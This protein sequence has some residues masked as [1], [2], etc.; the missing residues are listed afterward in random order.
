MF[1]EI[2][3]GNVYE[4]FLEKKKIEYKLTQRNYDE[5]SKHETDKMKLI[6]IIRKPK[7]KLTEFPG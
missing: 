5:M 2:S 6:K 3:T 1:C 4:E 7:T